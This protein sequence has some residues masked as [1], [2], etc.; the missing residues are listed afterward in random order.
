M[1]DE[2]PGGGAGSSHVTA[3]GWSVERGSEGF[4]A[5]RSVWI[6]CRI[7]ERMLKLG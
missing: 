1:C 7:G 3:G 6:Q 4:D 5:E 2:L